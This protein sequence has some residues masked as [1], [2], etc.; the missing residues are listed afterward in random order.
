VKN[1]LRVAKQRKTVGVPIFYVVYFR[2]ICPARG[3][4]DC[5][6]AAFG[7]ALCQIFFRERGPFRMSLMGEFML[8]DQ[9]EEPIEEVAKAP[10]TGLSLNSGLANSIPS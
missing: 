10:S 1:A 9:F 5:T 2:D 4:F 3:R 6:Y 7:R 8:R